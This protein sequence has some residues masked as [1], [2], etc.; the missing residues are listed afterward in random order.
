MHPQITYEMAKLRQAE[1]LAEADRERLARRVAAGSA[2]AKADPIR[3]R[4]RVA[5]LFGA[6]WPSIAKGTTR[7][8]GA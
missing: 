6:G 1:F 8:A 2:V 7:P 3:F 5:R 4:A